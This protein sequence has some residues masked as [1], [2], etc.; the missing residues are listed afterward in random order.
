MHTTVIHKSPVFFTVQ[1]SRSHTFRC[2]CN[3]WIAG[4]FR[5]FVQSLYASTQC[6]KLVLSTI[7]T[8][9]FYVCLFKFIFHPKVFLS[10]L[11]ENQECRQAKAFKI[12]TKWQIQ[13]AF[14]YVHCTLIESPNLIQLAQQMLFP[15]LIYLSLCFK[16][17]K[18][19][20]L[21]LTYLLFK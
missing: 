1:F 16:A 5:G 11:N 20:R 10:A 3:V 2:P 14:Q 18:V 13:N 8:C 7:Y 21:H 12:L 6:S 17:V 19:N 9:Q 15:L 4:L